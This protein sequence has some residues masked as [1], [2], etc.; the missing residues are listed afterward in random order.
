MAHKIFQPFQRFEFECFFNYIL[1]YFST[2]LVWEFF[3]RSIDAVVCAWCGVRMWNRLSHMLFGRFSMAIAIGDVTVAS[4]TY[5]FSS[6]SNLC[7]RQHFEWNRNYTFPFN[8]AIWIL[9]RQRTAV[10][11]KFRNQ[12]AEKRIADAMAIEMCLTLLFGLI[13]LLLWREKMKVYV[14]SAYAMRRIWYSLF[15]VCLC[16]AWRSIFSKVIEPIFSSL[17]LCFVVVLFIYVFTTSERTP[18]WLKMQLNVEPSAAYSF[19]RCGMPTNYQQKTHHFSFHHSIAIRCKI[20]ILRRNQFSFVVIMIA[21]IVLCYWFRCRHS[22]RIF[23]TNNKWDGWS[24]SL[25]LAFILS[26]D[27]HI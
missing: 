4:H 19:L 26:R 9:F 2:L 18:G 17:F 8:D 11:Q 20:I 21:F 12:K 15:I 13:L 6:N 7:E 23:M 24:R 22:K 10:A 3:I 1:L 5:D 27:Q 25:F 16:I 14:W